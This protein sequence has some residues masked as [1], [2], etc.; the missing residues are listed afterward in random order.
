[1][2]APQY[3]IPLKDRQKKDSPPGGK[4]FYWDDWICELHYDSQA[5]HSTSDALWGKF[6]NLV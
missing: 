5:R 4:P 3:S 1:M 2:P 6:A